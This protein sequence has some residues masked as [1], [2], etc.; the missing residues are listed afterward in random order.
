MATA[1]GKRYRCPVCEAEL[2]C[3]RPGDGS[4]VCCG[5]EMPLKEAKA[6]PTSD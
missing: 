3:T 6:L 5:E 1:L 2:L 4:L